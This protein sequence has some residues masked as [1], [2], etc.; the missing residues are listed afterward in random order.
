[1]PAMA[2]A[3]R[4]R[5]PVLLRS[6][7]ETRRSRDPVAGRSHGRRVKPARRKKVVVLV[8]VTA[9]ALALAA[10]GTPNSPGVANLG[11]GNTHG[12]GTTT[13][14]KAKGNPNGLLVEWAACMRLHGDPSQSDP[15]IDSHGGIN[16]F[17][18]GSNSNSI[19]GEVHNGTA[20]CNEYLAAASAALRVGAT[21]LQPPD[22]AA[23]V[24]YAQCMRTHG[25]PNFPDPGTGET[26]NLEGA[27]IDPNSPFFLRANNVC[28]RQIHAPSWWISGA[29]LPG[30]ISV[31]SGPSQGATP[32]GPNRSTPRPTG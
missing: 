16:I 7:S 28:G 13:I 21:D 4:L 20:P 9:T 27:G 22:Q 8:S 30:N 11:Q 29:G 14:T 12:H 17:I 6:R 26:T 15:T 31:E 18:S 10:C 23:L 5:Q 25:E 24:A 19:S 32:S 2:S 3:E 1:M